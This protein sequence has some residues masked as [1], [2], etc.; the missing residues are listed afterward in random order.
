MRLFVSNI[1]FWNCIV[2]DV[3]CKILCLFEYRLLIF[4]ERGFCEVVLFLFL[5][6]D[7]LFELLVDDDDN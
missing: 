5:S 1:V 3:C 6:E 2:C 7:C 4:F